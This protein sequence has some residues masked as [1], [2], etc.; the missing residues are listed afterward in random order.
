MT[1]PTIHTNGTGSQTLLDGYVSAFLAVRG[2]IDDIRRIEFNA[3][4]YY[5][6]GDQAWP[7][8]RNEM[9]ERIRK[10]DAVA[11]ELEAIAD[12]I[13]TLVAEREDRK[14]SHGQN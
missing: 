11:D 14:A 8:A 4:D 12:H 5:P 6:Q 2:A 13:Q 9:Q 10:L 1:F 3:R 7:A